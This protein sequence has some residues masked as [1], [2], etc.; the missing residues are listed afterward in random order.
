M[1]KLKNILII[2]CLLFSCSILKLSAQQNVQFSQYIF[3]GIAIN[4]AYAGYK[5]DWYVNATYRQQW[6]SFPGA[7][8]S[9]TISADGIAGTT[10]KNKA[11]AIQAIWDKLGAQ[12]NLA[13]Y[14]TYAYRIQLDD[15]DTKRLT[16]GLSL[17]LHQYAINGSLFVYNEE[18]DPNIPVN[19]ISTI[20]P[21]ARFGIYYN[22]SKFFVGLSFMEMLSGENQSKVYFG[23]GIQFA[24][25]K[26]TPHLYF[27][28][29][30]IKNIS[31]SL[32]I[33]P[34][35]LIKEDFNGPTSI[36]LNCMALLSKTVWVGASYRTA[37]NFW[38]KPALQE[39]LSKRG[40]VAGILELFTGNNMRIGYSYDYIVSGLNNYQGGSHEISIGFL[41]P[42]KFDGQNIKSPRYF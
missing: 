4:P 19:R 5:E 10:N 24:N 41:I 22:S 15:A 36:D 38:N 17:G 32:I 23:N 40:A 13:V 26:R 37:F 12:E 2:Y 18:N 11:V 21:D 30:G 34:S 9:A 8:A 20:K 16:F 29:G 14:G 7:P 31:E 27:T 39:G 33:K 42:K 3:N 35:V 28:V 1:N 6:T 25:L